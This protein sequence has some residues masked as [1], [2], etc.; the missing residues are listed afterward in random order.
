MAVRA[1]VFDVFGTLVD[2]RAGV[3]EAFEASA[4]EGHGGE[5]ADDWRSRYRP[6][7][8]E[9]NEGERPWGN[10]D[11]LHLVTLG[12]L[13]SERGIELP[14]D[15]REELVRAWHRLDPWPDVG[16]G[17]AAL[18]E[19]HVTATLSNAHVAMLVDLARHGDL[20]FDA[21][22]SA[23]L[24]KRYKPARETYLAAAGYLGVEP[25]ELMLVAAH[26]WDLEGAARA[27]LRT[28]F[29]DRPREH[30]PK[31]QSHDDPGAD[32]SVSSLPELAEHL[33]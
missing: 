15:E 17:L 18:R 2:W 31:G 19:R 27:G 25:G 7:L 22:L 21:I 28:A 12:D 14:L 5:L 26:P 23:E 20:R 9:V 30:G 1:L 13:L 4:I 8:S 10:F 24:T 16:E 32:Q 33:R 6:I 3:A 29:I 11:E